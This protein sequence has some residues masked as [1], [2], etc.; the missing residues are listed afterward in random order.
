MTNRTRFCLSSISFLDQPRGGIVA[1]TK[2]YEST[3]FGRNG[4]SSSLKQLASAIEPSLQRYLGTGYI[5]LHQ[6]QARDADAP[7]GE[8]LRTLGD[9]IPADKIR[10]IRY[11]NLKAWQGAVTLWAIKSLGFFLDAGPRAPRGIH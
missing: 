6:G 11:S 10:Y 8:T 4:R 2:G 9:L 1:V 3:T 5:E 7:L